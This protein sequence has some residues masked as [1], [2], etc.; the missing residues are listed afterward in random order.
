MVTEHVEE[1]WLKRSII[2]EVKEAWIIPL[3]IAQKYNITPYSK[4]EIKTRGYLYAYNRQGKI[5]VLQ[6]RENV[7]KVITVVFLEGVMKEN[8]EREN[9]EKWKKLSNYFLI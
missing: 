8:F 5:F 3:E 9:K 2:K 7:L 6:L 4:Q 1:R